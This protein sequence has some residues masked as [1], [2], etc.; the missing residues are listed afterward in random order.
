MIKIK[1]SNPTLS[2]KVLDNYAFDNTD[3][4]VMTI[5][6]TVNKVA[7]MLALVVAG[8][9][10]TWSKVFAAV[11]TASGMSAVGGLIAVGGI[12]GFIVALITVF[13]KKRANITAPIYAILEG[14]FLG[15]ISAYF[16]SRMP[17]LVMRAV[18]L[19]FAVLFSLLFA[20]KTGI[21][22]VTQKFRAGVIA[23]TMG[24][25]VAYLLSFIL[26]MFGINMSFMH[27]G[28]TMG[29]IISVVI[30]VVAA[31]N[32]VLDFDFIEQGSQAG[33]PKYF[34]WYGAFGL[35]VT[36][37]WLYLEILRLLSLL[38]NRN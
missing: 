23:A 32:L 7:L 11:D 12:G 33:L 21:I 10:Y 9:A 25:A 20:Y 31:L 35:M 16:E 37:I 27:G 24:I 22:K 19:T 18:L 36:L 30:V 5:Q 28:G 8:A 34:E 26:G 29:I 4:A 6:G 2:K 14:L 13:N 17:G 15:G 1:S 38:S 3:S